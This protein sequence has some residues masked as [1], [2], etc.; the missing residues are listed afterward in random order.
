MEVRIIK[1][2]DFKTH[3]TV[4]GVSIRV[5]GGRLYCKYPVGHQGYKTITEANK[6]KKNVIEQLSNGCRIEY[7]Q[8]GS[9][10]LNKHELVR[11]IQK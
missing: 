8:N 2:F 6:A 1:N 7:G 5:D 4:F 9:A 3:E 10:G 11:I